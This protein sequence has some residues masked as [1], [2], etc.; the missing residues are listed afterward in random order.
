M[1]LEPTVLSF[2][3]A[4]QPPMRCL[5]ATNAQEFFVRFDKME[6]PECR[7][8]LI[9]DV[10]ALDPDDREKFLTK[11]YYLTVHELS[12]ESNR[13]ARQTDEISRRVAGIRIEQNQIAEMQNDFV[14]EGVVQRS[15]GYPWSQMIFAIIAS[16]GRFISAVLF[17]VLGDLCPQFLIP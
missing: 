17:Y 16:I 14:R 8:R 13:L 7:E 10:H 4:S 12:R 3:I 2:D 9:V 15:E 11:F 6:G 1:S 5:A